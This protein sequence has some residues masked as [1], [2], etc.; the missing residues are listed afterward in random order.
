MGLRNKRIDALLT[1]TKFSNLFSVKPEPDT[2]FSN[3]N[4]VKPE[5]IAELLNLD[6]V[7]LNPNFIRF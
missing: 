7:E 6:L 3:L 1:G 5:P 2:E 4:W